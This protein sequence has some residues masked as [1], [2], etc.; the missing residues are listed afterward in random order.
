M[1]SEK[2]HQI[3][4]D[5]L[6]VFPPDSD[7]PRHRYTR[8]TWIFPNHIDIAVDFARQL[9][10]KYQANA[11]IAMLGALLHDAGLAYKRETASPAGH[12]GR[13]VE[14]AQ[15]SLPKYSYDTQLIDEVIKCIAATEPEV[16]PATL[17]AKIVRSADALSHM[18]SVHY[19]AKAMFADDLEDGISFVEKKIEKDFYKVCLDDERQMVQPVYD[20]YSKIIRQYRTG[21]IISL[22]N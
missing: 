9:A 17:E 18:L 21:E 19:L 5:L 3:R 4:T 22:T 20:Y 6:E 12:E 10:D 16:E 2:Y 7:N 8:R 15:E 1:N 13:S 14:Y 11:E